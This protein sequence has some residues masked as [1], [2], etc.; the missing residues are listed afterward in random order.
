M[1]KCIA[2]ILTL[3][4]LMSR[5][6]AFAITTESLSLKENMSF[7]EAVKEADKAFDKVRKEFEVFDFLS[8]YAKVTL[9]IK[10]TGLWDGKRVG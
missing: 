5:A 6:S 10:L 7:D 9:A 8:D 2:L 1:K 4:I 3:T